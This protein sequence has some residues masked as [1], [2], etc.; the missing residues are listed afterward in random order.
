M[1][2]IVKRLDPHQ[3]LIETEETTP[4]ACFPHNTGLLEVMDKT[5]EP[6]VLVESYL[7]DEFRQGKEIHLNAT[8]T[9]RLVPDGNTIDLTEKVRKLAAESS[10]HL[11]CKASEDIVPV[12]D[13]MANGLDRALFIHRLQ[14]VQKV[15][16]VSTSLIQPRWY[17]WN[18][19]V[20]DQAEKHWKDTGE[21]SPET[22]PFFEEL[23][24]QGFE[25]IVFTTRTAVDGPYDAWRTKV[26]NENIYLS[27]EGPPCGEEH[28][29]AG[30]E[31]FK[32]LLRAIYKR[33][34]I[35]PPAEVRTWTELWNGLSKYG[36]VTG[37]SDL[38]KMTEQAAYKTLDVSKFMPGT[39]LK[40]RGCGTEVEVPYSGVAPITCTTCGRTLSVWG[41]N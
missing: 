31:C 10:K 18:K 37:P 6:V 2:L 19:A 9:A 14:K 21:P 30:C 5:G 24:R 35:T 22:N 32:D 25:V 29:T 15:A 8:T 4:V 39:S 7:A 23:V 12:T 3:Q 26:P 40:C 16:V 27:V 41:E 1:K 34:G 17:A 33:L 11:P 20:I 28:K 36:V 38:D 13:Q